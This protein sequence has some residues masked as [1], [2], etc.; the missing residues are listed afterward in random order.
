LFTDSIFREGFALKYVHTTLLR[1][2]PN[3]GLLHHHS[4]NCTLLH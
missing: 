1:L 4:R 2:L 3:S